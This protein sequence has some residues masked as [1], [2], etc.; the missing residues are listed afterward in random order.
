MYTKKLSY[1]NKNNSRHPHQNAWDIFENDEHAAF[2]VIAAH[3]QIF[4]GGSLA[5]IL[6]GG[7]ILYIR[8]K[9]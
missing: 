3:V 2:I 7:L 8:I 1:Q 6:L 5:F 4:W 9:V